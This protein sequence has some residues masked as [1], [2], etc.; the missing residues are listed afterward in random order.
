MESLKILVI[1]DEPGLREGCRRICEAEGFQ[2]MVAQN[3]RAGLDIAE[4]NKIDCAL[5]DLKLPDMDGLDVLR[6]IR[7]VHP[8]ILAIIITG[9]GS[10]EIA[11]EAIKLGAYDFLSKPFTPDQLMKIVNKGLSEKK[12]RQEG[13]ALKQDR[14]E[15]AVD[16]LNSMTLVDEIMA[17]YNYRNSALIAMLQDIQKQF[18]YLPQN[19]LRYV[20]LRLN[21]PLPRVYSISTFYK[22]FSLKP[23][24][25]HLI[26]VCLGTACHVRG[27]MN[28]MER[29]ERELGIKNGE[30]TYDEKFSVKS[31]R[32]VGCCGLAP[33]IVIDEEFHGK[34]NQEQIPK[35]LARYQTD[36]STP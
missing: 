22:A 34:L 8:E 10:I 13:L 32:C 4:T 36:S 1:D 6:T 14:R 28:I 29:L 33:V 16:D 11:V 20:A 12:E 7:S 35:I 17:R 31:V 24:G 26:D 30:T 23:R 27:G 25:R 21:V 15:R 18:N 2:V 5:I 9:H 19:L 3:G